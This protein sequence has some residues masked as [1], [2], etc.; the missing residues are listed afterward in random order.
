MD[1][2]VEKRVKRMTADLEKIEEAFLDQTPEEEY[3]APIELPPNAYL[4]QFQKG[5][6]SSRKSLNN[7]NARLGGNQIAPTGHTMTAAPMPPPTQ[8]NYYQVDRQSQYPP[9]PPATQAQAQAQAQQSRQL[10][11]QQQIQQQ[12]Q[13]ASASNQAGQSTGLQKKR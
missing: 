3:E 7:N 10:Q 9:Q 11:Q 1:R 6:T 8:P 4:Q 5:P 12:Q 2:V 13:P